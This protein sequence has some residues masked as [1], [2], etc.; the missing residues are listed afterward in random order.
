[1]QSH[2][3]RS[4]AKLRIID[5]AF[6][7]FFMH[8]YEGASLSDI[9]KAVGI[10]K[11]SIYTHFASKEAIF[12]ELLQDALESECAFVKS[13]FA[14]DIEPSMPGEAYCHAFEARYESAI[15]LR[16]LIRMAYAAPVHLTDSSAAT[17]NV[18]IAALTEQIQQALQPYQL[19]SAQLA[20]YT[21]AYLGVIDSLSVELLYAEGLFERRFK[22]ML[23][24]YHTAIKQLTKK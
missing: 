23:M 20:L 1:M 11:A 8:G 15:T 19:D 16:F 9:A 6:A 24:L 5:A 4:S 21:D 18:Y 17:F 13:C 3:P 12:S 10:R 14:A 7:L 2:K 22:A